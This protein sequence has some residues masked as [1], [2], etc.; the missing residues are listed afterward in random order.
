M[1]LQRLQLPCFTTAG[2]RCG[3]HWLSWL[4]NLDTEA[5]KLMLVLCKASKAKLWMDL[6]PTRQLP[7][8]R[9]RCPSRAGRR[10][11]RRS[12]TQFQVCGLPERKGSNLAGM[13]EPRSTAARGPRESCWI[14]TDF[15]GCKERGGCCQ[16]QRRWW[17]VL[18]GL[19]LG[20]PALGRYPLIPKSC[21]PPSKFSGLL[22]QGE[23]P[24]EPKPV[25]AD[26]RDNL[27]PCSPQPP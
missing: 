24:F 2:E 15:S 8:V 27:S 5:L 7:R 13:R 16:Y 4:Q 14:S 26:L 1:G 20:T 11:R 17:V 18:C 23:S 21:T 12:R 3:D 10:R 19:K 22:L 25:C 9:T 6:G